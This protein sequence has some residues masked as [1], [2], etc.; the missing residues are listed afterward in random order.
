MV[1]LP[2]NSGRLELVSSQSLGIDAL[3]AM[4]T[5]R[6]KHRVADMDWFEALYRVYISAFLGGG[7][8][9]FLSGLSSDKLPARYTASAANASTTTIPM[10]S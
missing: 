5:E 6:R 9:L 8:I 10:T 1:L 3:H 4:R 7:A 2:L